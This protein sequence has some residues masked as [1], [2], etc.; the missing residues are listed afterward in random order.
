MMFIIKSDNT[1]LSTLFGFRM[2]DW[3]PI[4]LTRCALG[5]ITSSA[6]SFCLP[7][8]TIKLHSSIST[9]NDGFAHLAYLSQARASELL[10][11]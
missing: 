1:M 2:I 3:C 11:R 9:G 4:T 6:R 5:D 8:I 7:V 10:F